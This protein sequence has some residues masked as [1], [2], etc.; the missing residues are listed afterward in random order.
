MRLASALLI[1]ALSPPHSITRSF[2]SFTLH[3][4]IV[5]FH[6]MKWENK[7]NACHCQCAFCQSSMAKNIA[8]KWHK[9][10][11]VLDKFILISEWNET[12]KRITK[13]IKVWRYIYSTPRWKN[14]DVALT[15]P[16]LSVKKCKNKKWEGDRDK[17]QQRRIEREEIWCISGIILIHQPTIITLRP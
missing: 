6:T 11:V 5:R 13:Y 2:F 4:S 16:Q 15:H 3:I 17:H 10:Y 8:H 9:F 12:K 1:L 14:G 7:T